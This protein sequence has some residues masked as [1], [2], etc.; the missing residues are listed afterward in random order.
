MLTTPPLARSFSLVFMMHHSHCILSYFYGILALKD[1]AEFKVYDTADMG[2][3]PKTKKKTRPVLPFQACLAPTGVHTDRHV[4]SL[5]VTVPLCA[6]T[7]A[8]A[9]HT[10]G[11]VLVWTMLIVTLRTGF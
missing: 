4:P 5:L 9:R 7:A 11:P 3:D 1:E 6:S 2:A 10:P 8:V